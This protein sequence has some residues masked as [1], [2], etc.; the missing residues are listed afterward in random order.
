MTTTGTHLDVPL[1]G[2]GSVSAGGAASAA[3]LVLAGAHQLH[4]DE[5]GCRRRWDVTRGVVPPVRFKDRIAPRAR[6]GNPR[7]LAAYLDRRSRQ[8]RALMAKSAAVAP[9][10][11]S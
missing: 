7:S 10:R 9:R 1:A 2:A 8:R 5:R 6:L 11:P 4:P 3:T